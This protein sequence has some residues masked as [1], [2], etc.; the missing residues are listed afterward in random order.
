MNGT[1]GF[2]E[3]LPLPPDHPQ[4]G[5]CTS[6]GLNSETVPDTIPT[7]KLLRHTHLL[8]FLAR[9]LVA[10]SFSSPISISLNPSPSS[11]QESIKAFKN[12]SIDAAARNAL[13]NTARA[14]LSDE[15]SQ[16]RV[17]RFQ[18]VQIDTSR[19]KKDALLVFDL[20]PNLSLNI[21]NKRFKE[22]RSGFMSWAGQVVG[23]HPT[24][25]RALFT[26]KDGKIYGTIHSGSRAFEVRSISQDIYRITEFDITKFPDEGGGPPPQTPRPHPATIPPDTRMVS[27][28]GSTGSCQIDIMVLYTARV[29]TEAG[30]ESALL[31][32]INN[33]VD[34]VNTAF[35]ESGVVH[36]LNL[37]HT[38]QVSYSEQNE[39]S[40]EDILGT[41]LNPSGT[42]LAS[43]PTLRTN[44]QADIVSLWIDYNSNQYCGWA[45]DMPPLSVSPDLDESNAYHIVET[46][47]ALLKHSLAHEVGHN[48]GAYH[49]RGSDGL[50]SSDDINHDNRGDCNEN[51]WHGTIMAKKLGCGGD[52]FARQPYWSTPGLTYGDKTPMGRP[53]Y[54]NDAANN[55]R[56]IN[57]DTGHLVAKF[58]GA[59]CGSSSDST[60][61][62]A[63]TGLQI[64][65]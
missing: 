52:N 63:P 34:S 23:R 53:I 41:L 21:Q 62:A 11:A 3:V 37:V 22:I 44:K 59:A 9:L 10:L 1:S 13:D 38:E 2:H 27:G 7:I 6:N 5:C 39:L 55:S 24:M 61:P 12:L 17:L 56:F 45:N 28:D 31:D 4:I 58:K 64:Q 20:F 32:K 54:S 8:R 57:Q 36:Q 35:L 30:S 60:P 29:L 51:L 43:V 33:A 47:C 25:G 65:P 15:L 49:D 42:A 19:F 48:M 46:R 26:L 18:H 40:H 50:Q 14:Q 16:G